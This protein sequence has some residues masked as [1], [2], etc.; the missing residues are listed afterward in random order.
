MN[1][2]PMGD[3]FVWYCDWCDSTNHFHW[4]RLNREELTC[5]ACSRP[6]SDGDTEL[7]GLLPCAA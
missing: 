2:M 1:I 3:Y 6:R 7:H 5:A 4:S